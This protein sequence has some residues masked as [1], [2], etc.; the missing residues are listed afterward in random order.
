M[1][2]YAEGRIEVFTFLLW[3]NEREICYTAITRRNIKQ[4]A[5]FALIFWHTVF[6][7]FTTRRGGIHLRES[8]IVFRAQV[9][10]S[11]RHFVA[12]THADTSEVDAH[13]GIRNE[14]R[15]LENASG[16]N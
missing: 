1:P 4:S 9:V 6:F 14:D 5:Y 8:T 11:V 15:K 13:G 12:D 7:A 10:V 2:Y 3:A 16:K